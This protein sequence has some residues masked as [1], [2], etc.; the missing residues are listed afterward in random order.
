MGRPSYFENKKEVIYTEEI[1][2]FVRDKDLDLSVLLN[3]IVIMNRREIYL[4]QHNRSIWQGEN[5]KWYT[6]LFDETK[7]K[8]VLKKRNTR[9][10]IEDL[11]IEYYK[12]KEQKKELTFDDVYFKWREIHDE[13]VS[14][15]SVAK[16]DTDYKRFFYNTDFSRSSIKDITDEILVVF[17]TNKVKT[18]KLQ[19]ETTRKFFWY[20]KTVMLYAKKHKLIDENPTEFLQAKQFYK[21]CTEKVVPIEKQIIVVDDMKLLREQFRKDHEKKP[22]YIPTYAV[23]FASLTGMRVGEISALMWNDITDK[24]IIIHSSEKSD[25]TKTEFHI[26]TTKNGKSRLFPLTDEIRNLLEELKRVQEEYGYLCEWVFANENGRIH[27]KTISSCIKTK[28]RQ[29][30]VDVKGIH[31]FRKT[32]NSNMKKEGV[33]TIVA[34]TLLGHTEDVN[35]KYYTYDVASIEEKAEIISKI[36]EMSCAV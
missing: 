33:A 10:E 3:E 4:K 32:L 13:T 28:C 6:K 2:Q 35:K 21:H 8:L 17:V 16:Y 29:V 19:K 12:S 5:G 24:Y 15:N 1:S 23:E 25:R 27:T 30:G 14:E 26:D 22:N 34:A 11:I 9:K 7:Q 36:N 20:I 31:A 18:L